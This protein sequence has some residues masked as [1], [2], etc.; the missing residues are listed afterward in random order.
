MKRD[1]ALR[2]GKLHKPLLLA[3]LVLGVHLGSL[4][5]GTERPPPAVD[6]TD[7]PDDTRTTGTKTNTNPSNSTQ[8]DGG[9]ATTSSPSVETRP[10]EECV[11][12]TF[13]DDAAEVPFERL[14]AIVVDEEGEPVADILAQACGTN[15]CLQAK[16][17]TQGRVTI[18]EGT[19]I[20][21]LAFKYGDGLRFAQIVAELPAEQV[22]ELGSQTTLRLPD[23]TPDNRLVAGAVVES[24]GAA[25]ELDGAA[26]VKIDVLSYPDESEHVFVAREFERNVL[27]PSIAD[28]DFAAVWVFGPQKT[29]FC[30]PAKLN[31]PNTAEFEP[32]TPVELYILVT[33][34]EGHFA[35]YAEWG[36]VGTAT[37]S[38]DGAR[39][40][41]D[42]DSGLPELGII[43]VRPVLETNQGD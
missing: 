38:D 13:E 4:G 6:P 28:Q 11:V 21:K 2:L 10:G 24:S 17:D 41:T 34:I 8:T 33:G 20:A 15:V 43:G 7:D 29:E 26:S 23:G 14:S 42:P 40:E 16:T 9:G 36:K 30:P 32:G 1:R 22:H 27:P 5:C 25:L 37:V 3:G 19:S 31:L 18:A 39:I 35:R 12:P